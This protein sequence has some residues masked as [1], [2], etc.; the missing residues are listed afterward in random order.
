[1]EIDGKVL[2]HET[3]YFRDRR[4]NAVARRKNGE[5]SLLV[6]EIEGEEAYIPVPVTDRLEVARNV[7][8]QLLE[9]IDDSN[10]EKTKKVIYEAVFKAP[11]IYFLNNEVEPRN[12]LDKTNIGIYVKPQLPWQK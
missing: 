11:A 3:F 8:E 4:V 5:I 7:R 1:M 2:S 6:T 12:R 10:Q 9:R